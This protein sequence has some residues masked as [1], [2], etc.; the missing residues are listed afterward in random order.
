MP[1]LVYIYDTN[2]GNTIVKRADSQHMISGGLASGSISPGSILSS[3]IGSGQI[4]PHI[5]GNALLS[6]HFS[7]GS[8]PGSAF[9]PRDIYLDAGGNHNIYGNASLLDATARTVS[10]NVLQTG[11][12]GSWMEM[13]RFTPD[14]ADP[15][16]SFGY[17]VH[18]GAHTEPANMLKVTGDM[19][20]TGSIYMLTTKTIGISGVNYI[21]FIGGAGASIEHVADFHIFRTGPVYIDNALSIAARGNSPADGDYFTFQARDSDTDTLVEVGRVFGA[22]NPYFSFGGSQQNKFYNSAAIDFGGNISL[23]QAT[24][25]LYGSGNGRIILGMNGEVTIDIN[26]TSGDVITF[27]G[28]AFYFGGVTTIN[29]TYS[30]D[31]GSDDTNYFTIRAKDTGV[32]MVEV[33]RVIGAADPYISFG[34]SQ[35]FKFYNSGYGEGYYVGAASTN[36]LI[37]DASNGSSTATL[38][39]GNA[40]I[41]VVSDIRVKDN[42]TPYNIDAMSLIRQFTVIE[43]D[44]LDQY[45]PFG[46]GIYT[47]KYVG[48]S[49][50]DV[51]QLT[52]WVVNTQGGA[53]CQKCL[54]GQRC[55]EHLPWQMRGE[56]LIGVL[57]KALQEADERIQKLESILCRY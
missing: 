18:I 19:D 12:P 30:L 46:G 8:I 32:G 29:N 35:Q 51:F 2:T 57:V 47:D 53:D 25:T 54:S 11:S 1:E 5:A 13:L 48:L 31:S 28:A 20:V 14:A 56:L 9:L 4:G 43:F 21:G 34:G 7:S 22:S 36:N 39:I 55:D 37:D 17:K 33:G 16:T 27:S 49:A 45:R 38:Y 10:V 15:W 42:I 26:G 40:S 52:P 50:Q 6:A 24:T 23:T 44:Y 3:H 41:A